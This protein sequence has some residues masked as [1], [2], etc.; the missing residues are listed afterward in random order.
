MNKVLIIEDQNTLCDEIYDW[1]QFEG[2]ESYAANN[3]KDG[4][5]LAFKHLPDIIVCD[6][7]M[8]EM[9]GNEVLFNLRNNPDTSLIPFI[10]MT[11]MAERSQ[12]RAGM[13]LGADDYITKPF[14]REELLNAVNSRLKKSGEIREKSD[15]VLNELRNNLITSLPH[16]LRT[17]LNGILGFSNLLKEEAGNL[18]PEEIQRIGEGI[19]TSGVRLFRLI[20]NYLLYAQLELRK[21]GE[22]NVHAFSNATEI[23]G[24]TGDKIAAR[25]NRRDDLR[26]IAREATVNMSESEFKKIVEELVDN[27][28][29]FSTP[30]Q[31]VIVECRE[32]KGFFTLVVEDQGRGML[33]E[34][35]KK[36]G[37]FMQFERT[38]YEQQGF[39]LGLVISKQIAE[40][41]NGS[42]KIASESGQGTRITV[43]IPTH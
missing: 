23:C 1:F 39:G 32:E 3:G 11:A 34:D 41:F 43:Q 4:L 16:E 27:A 6:I 9:D 22:V 28:F 5:A 24:L 10:F 21:T 38:M 33:A 14:T 20:Q 12:V 18:V 17:P 29:K 42:L 35:M 13:E 2:F 30:G 36:I 19:N 37:A 40:L 26:F 31:R 25:Y 8:P 7:M 15:A